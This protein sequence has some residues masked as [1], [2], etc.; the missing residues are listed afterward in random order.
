MDHFKK[1]P[2]LFLVFTFLAPVIAL[3]QTV[4]CPSIVEDALSA[5][6]NA[7]ED[8]GRNEACYGNINLFAEP[9]ENVPDFT[10]E[11]AGDR[12]KLETV[13]SLALSPMDTVMDIWGV[14]LLRVQANIPDTLPGQNVTF[15]LFGNVAIEN[16]QSEVETSSD[17]TPSPAAAPQYG[18]MQS[19]YF[20][21][22]VGDAPCAEAPDSGILIQT[23]KGAARINLLVNE[24]SITLG[25]TAYLQAQPDGDMVINV[26]EGHATV[27]ALGTTVVAPA[28]TRVRVPLD[29]NLQA[30]GAPVGPEPYDA[31]GLVAL[32]MAH[33]PEI[34]SVA[35]PL[36]AGQIAALN[37]PTTGVW[38]VTY[39]FE[40]IDIRDCAA[41]FY[42][43][44][45]SEVRIEYDPDGSI[46]WKG[47]PLYRVGTGIYEGESSS[48]GQY[49]STQ[50]YRLIMVSPTEIMGQDTWILTSCTINNNFRLVLA[51]PS[52]LQPTPA[53]PAS[54]ET[55]VEET[56]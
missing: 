4:D 53:A 2:I 12:V 51:E 36:T 33:L 25:S 15:L 43:L 40:K 42:G 3:A 47:M 32:P 14:A 6:D 5:T 7:C 8:T 37:L 44:N 54:T 34:V 24:V 19:F 21:T 20:K 35:A 22:G 29:V 16:A 11:Q 28:G 9:Q 46:I 41:N 30:T 23:P 48:T 52:P 38:I 13:K 18:P 56:P 27:T 31:A 17:A 1:H 26:V 45:G 10:F 49:P 55:A 50:R 39:D